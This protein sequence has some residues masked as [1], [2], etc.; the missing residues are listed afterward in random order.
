MAFSCNKYWSN[1][2]SME[3]MLVR[4]CIILCLL[5]SYC[6]PRYHLCN[7]SLWE[8]FYLCALVGQKN[9]QNKYLHGGKQYFSKSTVPLQK[10]ITPRLKIKSRWN[11]I[12]F[13]SWLCI[14]QLVSM[15]KFLV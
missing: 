1:M 11:K 10:I 13:L 6:S 4:C 8:G 15:A 7:H 3:Y 5:W 9:S 2:T 14:D 12:I